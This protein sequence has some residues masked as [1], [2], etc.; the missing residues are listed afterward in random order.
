MNSLQ[1]VNTLSWYFFVIIAC[2]YQQNGRH[3]YGDGKK[4][5]TEWNY[6]EACTLD[7]LRFSSINYFVQDKW[8][9]WHSLPIQNV[10]YVNL[11]YRCITHM[12][13]DTLLYQNHSIDHLTWPSYWC[14]TPFYWPSHMAI[15]L[16]SNTI[17]LTISH[18]HP[19][20]FQHHSIGHLTWPSHWCPQPFHRPSYMAILLMS[21]TIPLTISHGNPIDV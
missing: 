20:D 12:L 4:W 6:R 21:T 11:Y 14:L 13:N 5:I 8:I 15:L 10:S 16:M 17:I 1:P 7:W 19:I 18:G 2:D 3:N 9:K